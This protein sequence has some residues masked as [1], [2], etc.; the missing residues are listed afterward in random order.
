MQKRKKGAAEQDD[1]E[2][3]S[4]GQ[5]GKTAASET[6]DFPYAALV[7]GAADGI[8]VLQDGA[9]QF[10]NSAALEKLGYAPG[11]ILG[12]L[13]VDHVTEAMRVLASERHD[14]RLAGRGVRRSTEFDLVRKDGSIL[15]A[16]V[17][18]SRFI[19]RDRPALLVFFHDVTEQRGAQEALRQSEE[20]FRILFEQAADVI[21]LLEIPEDGVPLIRDANYA[22]FKI[23]GY[24][25]G[26]LIDRPISS[27]D[28]APD[29][30]DVIRARRGDIQSGAA[31]VFTVS[32]RCKDGSIREF[33]CSVA[34]MKIGE[35]TY[36]ISVERDTTER[37]QARDQLRG[38]EERYRILVKQSV[39]GIGVSRGNQV[40]F[41][42]QAL[43][44]MFGYD[45]LEEFAKVPLLEH[46]APAS[47]D[48]IARLLRSASDGDPAERTFDY[49]IQ[50]RDGETRR[51]RAFMSHL[52]MQGVRYT[53]TTFEDITDQRRAE[54]KLRAS[55]AQLANALRLAHAG[56]WEYDVARDAFTFNDDFYRIFR[57]TADEVGGY[58]MP[59]A[60]YAKRFCHPD[61]MHRVAQEIEAAIE[62][63]NPY[64]GRELVHR[65][66]YADGGVGYIA[67]RFF[68]VKDSEGHTVKTYGV[69]QDITERLEAE[70]RVRDAL[71]GTIQAVA[72]TIEARDPYTAGHQ[73]RVTR[74]AV[75]IA[76]KMG[77]D[78]EQV[79]GIRVAATLHDIGKTST[80]AEILS[81]PGQLSQQEFRL[82]QEHPRVAYTILKGIA[83]PWPVADIILQHHERLDGTGYPQGLTEEGGILVGARIVA[84]ADVVEA[85]TTHR[86]YRPALGI[87]AALDEIRSNR[88]TQF[89]PVVVDACLELFESGEFSFDE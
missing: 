74:L 65:I 60:E 64:Y 75:A 33:E 69:N 78:D 83:F 52:T 38:S 15:P 8:V 5:P 51:L 3:H 28:T 6:S 88:G 71:E 56:H 48:M 35:I 41:A 59:S 37:K 24:E 9:V 36:A 21:L 81:K 29:L 27:I 77:L 44:N 79:E 23:L 43:L 66:L 18:A 26:D 70:K 67:V 62:T 10:A 30:E 89:D 4:R 16:E 11:E 47:R 7:E 54:E 39:M 45:T 46:V 72:E 40:V 49:E 1:Q 13:F 86:P 14:A 12:S 85:M 19:Y 2:S 34:E 17:N 76:R 61:D 25:R 31:P 20:R 73:K 22:T 55:E 32:H 42:N 68:V 57:T 63:D 50:R 87:E 84:V 53:Q 58:V 82:I 80:P